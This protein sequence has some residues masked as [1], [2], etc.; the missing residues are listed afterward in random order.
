MHPDSNVTALIRHFLTTAGGILVSRGILTASDLEWIVGGLL[1]L[2]GILWSLYNKKRMTAAIDTALEMPPGTT[3]EKL[4]TE[5]K[6]TG[7]L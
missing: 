1:T 3:R 5:A 6:R 7:A 4:K 2:G